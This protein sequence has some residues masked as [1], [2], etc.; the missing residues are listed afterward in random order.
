MKAI[1]EL[2]VNDPDTILNSLKPDIEQTKRFQVEFKKEDKKILMYVKASD[3]TA[4]LAGLNS[5]MRLI[6]TSMELI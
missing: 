2:D 1:I 4:L 6:K 3:I 5:Y